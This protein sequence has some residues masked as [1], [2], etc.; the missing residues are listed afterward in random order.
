MIAALTGVGVALGLFY[1]TW[2]FYLAVMSLM[3]ARDAGILSPF[4]HALGLPILWVG[5]VLDMLFN[6]LI[7]TP[8]FLELPQEVLTTGRVSRHVR[9][10]PNGGYGPWRSRLALFL[11]R[12]LLDVFDPSGTHCK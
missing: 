6:V 10:I 7:C 1:A 9:A 3:R 4:A 12:N 8:L 2:I 11:C 5:L